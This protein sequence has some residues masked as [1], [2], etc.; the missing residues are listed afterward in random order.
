M[1][2]LLKLFAQGVLGQATST[3]RKVVHGKHM[4]LSCVT[5][6]LPKQLAGPKVTE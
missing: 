1:L 2:F 6:V 4:Y 3:K 5:P